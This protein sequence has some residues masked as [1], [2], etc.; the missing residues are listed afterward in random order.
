MKLGIVG[1]NFIS[2]WL[3]EAAE[4]VAEVELDAVFSRKQETGDAFAKKH[5]IPA[6]YTDWEEFLQ[7]DIEAVYIATPTYAHCGQTLDALQH[8]KH[9]LCEKIL[10]VNEQEAQKMF[11]CAKDNQ[12]VLLEA[13]KPDFDPGMKRLEQELPKI[14]TLRRA[15]VEYCQYS[16]RYDKFRQGEILNAFNPELSNAAIMDI[17]VYCIHTIARMFGMPKEVKAVATKLSNGF[18]GMGIVSMQYE[19][20]VAEA[21]YS[22]ITES[23]NRTVFQGEE[24][25]ILIDKAAT[26][27]EMEIIYRNGDKEIIPLRPAP[28]NMIYE[29]QEFVHLIR[30]GCVEHPYRTYSLDTMRITD[31]AR[32]QT[33]TTFPA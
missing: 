11:D 24:G 29:V 28:N 6:V 30:E 7:S 1:T 17:G 10:A 16:S 12:V 13:M 18:E 27:H 31:E 20:M 5:G 19:N 21:I 8:K 4:Q 2:D 23:V 14:G 9:V 26:P 22:K 33:G 32:R 25:S 3:V 15:T